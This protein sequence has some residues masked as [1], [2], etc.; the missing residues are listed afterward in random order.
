M[1]HP[2]VLL[3]AA[4]IVASLA[5]PVRA[6]DAP[7]APTAATA[8][9]GTQVLSLALVGKHPRVQVRLEGAPR[10]LSFVVDTAAGASVI[11]AALA[12]RLGLFDADARSHA[13]KGA[14][15]AA[16]NGR[17]TRLLGLSSGRFGWHAQLL[18]MDLSHIAEADA[19]AIDGIVGNDLLARFDVRFDL[20]AGRLELAPAGTL[21]TAD[22][23]PNALPQ[24]APSLQRFAFAQ[25]RA[26]DG[27][28]AV[29]AVAVID[30]GA[31]QTIL[32]PPAARALG[33]VEGDARLR[34]RA[35]GTRGLGSTTTETWLY[36]LPSLRVGG[37]ELAP[38]EVRL[39]AL[40]VFA[41]LGL[42]Q[43]PAMILGVDALLTRPWTVAAG[44]ARVCPGPVATS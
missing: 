34:V 23:L 2:F 5:L 39:S 36:T 24:R 33:V 28:R 20:P 26:G 29:E 19:P 15:G 14:G 16:G 32:N 38:L 1:R 40:P 31:A 21:S 12:E 41:V 42:E 25:V 43:R 6:G 27:Q 10:P 8:A 3:S 11:D 37:A 7:A 30:S 18:A 13:V 35:Q 22:C 9:T 17:V 4:T 44:G